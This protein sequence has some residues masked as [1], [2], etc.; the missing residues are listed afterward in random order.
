MTKNM[1]RRA[2]ALG[3]V[4]ALGASAFVASPAYAVEN[5]SLTSYWGAGKANEFVGVTKVD[6]GYVLN[7]EFADIGS[8]T[9]SNLKYQVEILNDNTDYENV[10]DGT[11]DNDALFNNANRISFFTTLADR[12]EASADD[13]TDFAATEINGVANDNIVVVQPVYRNASTLAASAVTASTIDTTTH[14]LALTIANGHGLAVGDVVA[15]AGVAG[16]GTGTPN[17]AGDYNVT[18]V[19]DTVVTATKASS[20]AGN[21]D[22]NAAATLSTATIAK[23]VALAAA[24]GQNHL[25]YIEAPA[26]DDYDGDTTAD[27]TLIIRV[28]AWIDETSDNII[29]NE[30][31]SSSVTLTFEPTKAVVATG[32]FDF[33]QIGQT[34]DVS[35]QFTLNVNNQNFFNVISEGDA[36]PNVDFSGAALDA[37]ETDRSVTFNSTLDQMEFI[38]DAAGTVVALNAGAL[39]ATVQQ[40]SANLTGAT[41]PYFTD[42]E[43]ES[44]FTTTIGDNSVEELD[45]ALGVVS[46]ASN[47][48]ATGT[49]LLAA[50]TTE[51]IE[52][53][54]SLPFTVTVWDDKSAGTNAGSGVSVLVTLA[55]V[56]GDLGTTTLTTEAKTLKSTGVDS[57]SFTKVTDSNGQISFTVAADKAVTGESFTVNAV[58]ENKGLLAAVLTAQT[59]KFE[60]EDFDVLQNPSDINYTV[61]PNGTISVEYTVVNQF[62]QVPTSGLQLGV[63]RGTAT[64]DRADT[65]STQANWSYVV[66]VSTTG[67]ASITIVDNGSATVEGGDTV[68]V[69]LQ[70]SAISGGGYIATGDSDTFLLAYDVDYTA[71]KNVAEI[72]NNGVKVGATAVY[73][74]AVEPDTLVDFDGRVDVAVPT[75]DADNTF[76]DKADLVADN[77]LRVYGTVTNSATNVGLSGVA[78]VI[79]ADGMNFASADSLVRASGLRLLNDS[80]VVTTGAN[81]VYQAWVRSSVGGMQ[82]IS[83]NAQG[84]TASAAVTFAAST[85]AA[86]GMALAVASAVT[87]GLTAD[88]KVTVTDKLGNPVSGVAV[89]F[90]ETGPGYLNSSSGTSDAD[91]EVIVNLITVKGD[92]GSSTIT[93]SATIDGVATAVVKTITVGAVASAKKVN[94]GSFKGYVALYA[95]GYEGQRMSA[96]VGADWVIVAAIPAATNDLFRAVEFVGAGVEISVRIYIDRVLVDT[97]PLLTK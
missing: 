48:T 88:V 21:A 84:A 52:G 34:A 19:S 25:L 96:K 14:T 93:A 24:V 72:S 23:K 31:K 95:K 15:V 37:A 10:N 57:V 53:T 70:E 8:A 59:I 17:L 44:V 66:P 42:S 76:A 58:A 27:D 18:V 41:T 71:L 74:V 85:G 54:K 45:L 26:F 12:L 4:V 39:T 9:A 86:T 94:A 65:A 62:G 13:L 33:A 50:S 78:V 55:D 30:Y 35:G 20:S 69:T 2:L 43:K 60:A 36:A 47:E 38:S 16:A 51:V 63:T 1:T 6:N 89:T 68:T 64:G 91:G 75:Y 73:A 40:A 61:A 29:G 82:T 7:T 56:S 32:S 3:S 83:I 81:G 97:I 92:T 5:I 67:R 46:S 49:S 11:G 90:K 77:L 80:I 22:N 87:D 79:S 28:T